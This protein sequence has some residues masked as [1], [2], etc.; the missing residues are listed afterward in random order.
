M[1]ILVERHRLLPG[2][3]FDRLKEASQNR[4]LKLRDVAA[5]VIQT[6]AEPEDA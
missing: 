1:G 3:A 5:R 4:N 6:G 2:Q